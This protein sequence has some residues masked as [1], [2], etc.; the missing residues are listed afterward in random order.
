MRLLKK[1]GADATI[2]VTK[3]DYLA[4]LR[5]AAPHGLDAALALAGGDALEQ[6][7]DQVNRGGR[8]AYVTGGGVMNTRT[9]LVQSPTVRPQQTG[10]TVT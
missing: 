5:A 10:R 4:Q 7:L 6:C 3:K 9:Q 1:L 2:D 8:I